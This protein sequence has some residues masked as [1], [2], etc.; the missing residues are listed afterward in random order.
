MKKLLTMAELAEALGVTKQAVSLAVKD[1]RIEEPE[2]ILGIA[3]GWTSEQLER[4]QKTY[5]RRNL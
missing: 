3:K 1:N 4:I 5:T 2:Y